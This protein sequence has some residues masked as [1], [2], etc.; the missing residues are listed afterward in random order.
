MSVADSPNP[1]RAIKDWLG[2]GNR[3]AYLFWGAIVAAVL[4]IADFEGRRGDA[5]EDVHLAPL[6]KIGIPIEVIATL[7]AYAAPPSDPITLLHK[8]DT[9]L[10]GDRVL[11]LWFAGQ[12]LDSALFRSVAVLDRLATLLWCASGRPLRKVRGRSTSL[13]SEGTIWIS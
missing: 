10:A 2:E 6:R 5:T 9:K 7:Q 3:V 8:P 13:R 1:V 4:Y 12:L 11:S